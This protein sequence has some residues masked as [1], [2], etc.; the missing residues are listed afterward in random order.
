MIDEQI[1]YIRTQDNTDSKRLIG[2]EKNLWT[3]LGI[4]GEP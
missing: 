2:Y 1:G 3:Y 4:V